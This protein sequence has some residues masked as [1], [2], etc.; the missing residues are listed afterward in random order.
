[1]GVGILMNKGDG[2]FLPVSN[3]GGMGSGV[4]VADFKGDSKDDLVIVDGTNIQILLGNGNGTFQAPAIISD[5]STP[6]V[7]AVGDFNSDNKADLVVV[8][9]GNNQ[10]ISVLFGNGNGT[11]QAHVDYPTGQF[12]G[13]VAVGDFDGDG[14]AD[15]AV[16]DPTGLSIFTNKGDGTFEARE[17]YSSGVAPVAI[18][19]G[20]FDLDGK[21][22]LATTNLLTSPLSYVGQYLPGSVSILLNG[23]GAIVAIRPSE[24]PSAIGAPIT[25]ATTVRAA[26][27]GALSPTGSVTLQDG[28]TTLGTAALTGNSAAFSVPALA[29]G[30]H[31]MSAH[32]SGDQN[33]RA[34]ST[35]LR[36]A[37]VAPD[38]SLSSSAVTPASVSAGQSASA[39]VTITSI[40]GF[41]GAVSLSCSVSPSP[42]GAPACSLSPATVQSTADSSA[43]STLNI[44]TAAPHLQLGSIQFPSSG[45]RMRAFWFPV[46]GIVVLGGL[47]GLHPKRG[48]RR[49]PVVSCWL[50][51]PGLWESGIW[52]G[53]ILA[54][55]LGLQACGGSQSTP[56]GGSSA[57][58]YVINIEGTSGG[59]QHSVSVTLS[60]H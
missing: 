53:L 56:S 17:E 49:K 15:I 43:A 6:G 51:V 23:T 37:V 54:G 55:L 10:S 45:G 2:T 28:T 3:L 9:G 21:L 35:V 60:V 7:V 32:Y 58:S 48:L 26:L 52:V 30:V 33:F 29:A 31:V 4:A 59:A 41:S 22:D 57:G 47:L 24:N 1:G 14:K 40:A 13:N 11:F 5:G 39:T 8:N 25:F 44:S 20:D 27:P 34:S 19:V 16:G 50:P 12:P 18:A 42:T 46:C 36:Q 38:F